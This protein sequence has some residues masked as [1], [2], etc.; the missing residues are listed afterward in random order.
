MGSV[1]KHY[2]DIYNNNNNNN[3]NN[4]HVSQLCYAM[5]TTV[6]RQHHSAYMYTTH[7]VC[8]I[9]TCAYCVYVAHLTAC[10]PPLLY[11]TT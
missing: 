2:Y 7:R 1:T 3:N 9:T 5:T 11:I 10:C 8:T 4:N 6:C